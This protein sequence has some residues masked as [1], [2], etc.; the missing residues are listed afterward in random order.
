MLGVLRE[1][2]SPRANLL[3]REKF[4]FMFLVFGSLNNKHKY[5]QTISK[6]PIYIL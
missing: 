4:V 2:A 3:E 6:F 1:V 5:T